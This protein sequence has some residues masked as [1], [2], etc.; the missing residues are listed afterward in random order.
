MGLVRA[1]ITLLVFLSCWL[2]SVSAFSATPNSTSQGAKKEVEAQG[3]LFESSHDE[4]VARAKKEGK[5]RVLSSLEPLKEMRE[6]FVRKYPFVDVQVQEITGT[7]A[8]QRFLREL[9]AGVQTDWDVANASS[10]FYGEYTPLM[11]RIDILGMARHRALQIP[12]AMIDPNNRNIVAITSQFAVVAYNKSL[13]SPEKVPVRWED[14]L[15]Q[16]FKGRKFVVDLRPHPYTAMIPLLGIDWV[17]EYCKK[18]AAQEPVWF[19]GQARVLPA[20]ATGEYMLHAGINY[21]FTLSAMKKDPTGNLQFKVIEP[22]PVSL[23]DTEGVLA[24]AAHPYAALLWLEFEAGPEGQAIIDRYAPLKSSLYA[25]DSA[26]EKILRGKK[27]S[28]LNWDTF[29][30]KEKWTGQVIEAFGFPKASQ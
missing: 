21:H 19:R 8:H 28:V 20:I 24:I 11:K 30:M 26:V 7:D 29:H 15:K 16:E 3:F 1:R 27:L 4:I 17:L 6:A 18:L 12:T 9:K 2:A 13:I 23:V 14:F 5:L 10:D 22:V 25:P